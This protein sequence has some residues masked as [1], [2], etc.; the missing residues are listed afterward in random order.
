MRS[1]GTAT[2]LELKRAEAVFVDVQLPGARPE[3]VG[4]LLLAY[5]HFK[6]RYFFAMPLISSIASVKRLFSTDS[7]SALLFWISSPSSC[8]FATAR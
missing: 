1:T 8:M 3:T 5:L 4:V 2:V 6:I 7:A